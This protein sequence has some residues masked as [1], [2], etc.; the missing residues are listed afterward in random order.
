MLWLYIHFPS[1]QLDCLQT[2]SSSSTLTIVE[3]QHLNEQAVVIVEDKKNRIV[4]L[5]T[6]AKPCGGNIAILAVT[7]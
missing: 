2:H 5:N 1:L 7:L 6:R 3:Q 4:Q